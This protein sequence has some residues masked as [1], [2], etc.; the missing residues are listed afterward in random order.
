MRKEAVCRK[1][2]RE[3]EKLFLKGEKCLSPS[4]PFLRR[5][6]PPGVS[7]QKPSKISEYGRQLRE[8]QKAKRIYGV[9][10]RQFKN[11]YEKASKRMGETSSI[12]LS[13]LERRLDNVI[14]RL[15]LAS[16]R[17][18]A[19]QFISH[20][21]FLVNRKKVNIPSYLVKKGDK[22]EIKESSAKL[23]I[24]LERKRELREIT[25]PSWLKLDREKMRGQVLY[26]PE[27]EEIQ[28]PIDESLI[29]EHYSK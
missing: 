21:H 29:I 23:P 5:S 16:S 11:Y 26:L 25:I 13:F 6:Y 27:R 12:F 3:G 8:K 15:G 17:K 7:G 2:R 10:E 19:R 4:C 1:C 24:F 20:G 14:Y 28:I 22:I 18:A 9:S